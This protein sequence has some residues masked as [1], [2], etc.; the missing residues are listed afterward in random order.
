MKKTKILH[1]FYRMDQGG[2]ENF[3]LNVLENINKEEFELS[4]A[5]ISGEKGVLDERI[6]EQGGKIY[7]F[8]EGKKSLGRMK[9]NLTR[10]I[11]DNGPFEVVHSH[12][13]FFSGYILLLA[14]KLNIPVRISHSHETYKGQK[15]TIKRKGYEMVMRYLI[16][17][18]ATFKFGCGKDACVH[19]YKKMD[20]KTYVIPN[21]IDTSKFSFNQSIRDEYRK[22]LN[23]EGNLVLG[24]VG[25][26][27]DQKDHAFLID[28]FEIVHKKKSNSKL[29]LVGTG[30]L[31]EIIKKKVSFLGLEDDVLF[32]KNRMDVNCIMQAMDLFVLPSK[33]EGLGIVLVEAQSNGLPC[34]TSTNVPHEVKITNSLKFLPKASAEIWAEEIL[35]GQWSRT[36]NK[37]EIIESGYDIKTTIYLLEKLYK[38]LL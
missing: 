18:N 23:V 5:M 26:F 14:K 30:S 29:V 25:R 21:G 37:K 31:I 19:L 9:K 7:Y 17:H 20:K 16:N 13:Y 22:D 11:T 15:Y 3:C 33:Y 2:V 12:C 28:I 4:F 36:N 32:L 27:E 8:T 38:G 34:L 24:N 6:I 1:V 10:I 35:N